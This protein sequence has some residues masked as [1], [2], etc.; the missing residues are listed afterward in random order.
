VAKGVGKDMEQED[1]GAGR[2][3]AETKGGRSMR[4]CTKDILSVLSC[5]WEREGWIG[6][7]D[8]ISEHK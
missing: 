8:V 3:Y 2:L 7:E 1:R 6:L 5:L 4:L